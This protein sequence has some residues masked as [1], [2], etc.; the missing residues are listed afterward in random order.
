[1]ILIENLS[2]SY[3]KDSRIINGLQ[4]SLS[5]CLIH[6]IVGL[7]G[8]GK[9]TLLNTIYGLKKQEEGKVLFNGSD[10]NKKSVSYLVSEN[11]FYSNITA[12]EYLSLFKN[13]H[14][15]I[16]K[17][18][19][20][21]KLPL[22]KLVDTYST[23]MKKKLAILGSLKQDKAIMILDE[24]FNGLDIE[25]CRIIRS[26]LLK[27][28]EKGKTIII[29]SHIIETLTNLCDHIHYLEYGKITHSCDKSE[30]QL[31]EEELFKE[32]ELKNEEALC[33]LINDH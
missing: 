21:F 4:L 12:R 28:K 33:E 13:I 11:F 8:A 20:L 10:L 16:E 15:D 1:M 26:I 19:A 23:G 25:T 27:L 32:I 22:D 14:F 17:W 31:F 24:P 5:E 7:N 30:F 2:V 18:N 3:K 9:T 29:T 6:A